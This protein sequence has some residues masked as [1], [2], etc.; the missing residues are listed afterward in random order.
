[1]TRDM[2]S[3]C[4]EADANLT[5]GVQSG[6]C[7]EGW[8]LINASALDTCNC[9]HVEVKDRCR[10]LGDAENQG[11]LRRSRSLCYKQCA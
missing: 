9:C 2:F 11:S 1:M 10:G 5:L 8:A 3:D 7:I 4:V 6:R